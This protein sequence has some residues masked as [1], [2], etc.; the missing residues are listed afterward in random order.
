MTA[1]DQERVAKRSAEEAFDVVFA[2]KKSIRELEGIFNFKFI[3]LF[4][5]LFFLF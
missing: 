5:F 3:I 2:L 4:R 1:A